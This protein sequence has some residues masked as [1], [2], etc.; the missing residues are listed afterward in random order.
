MRHK[1]IVGN[2]K[3]FTTACQLARDVVNRR[4]QE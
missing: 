4:G 2:G 3:M 1:R